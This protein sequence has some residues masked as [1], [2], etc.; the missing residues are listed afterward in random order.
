MMFMDHPHN[1]IAMAGAVVDRFAI[2]FLIP[3]VSLPFGDPANG[4]IIGLLLSLPSAIIS[5]AY[6]PIVGVGVVGG[7]IIGFL[8]KRFCASN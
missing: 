3:N 6:D 8:T 2:G 7:L 1:G 5:G 4:V